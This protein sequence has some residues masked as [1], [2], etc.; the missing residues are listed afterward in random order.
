MQRVIQN[1]IYGILAA[2]MALFIGS[3]LFLRA[4][5]NYVV[6]S[7]KP[8]L[9]QQHLLIL[10][11]LVILLVIASLVVYR[12]C[13]KLDRYRPQVVIPFI[14]GISLAIQLAIIFL[15]PRLPTDDSQTV[16]SLA[17]QMLNKGDYS[18]FQSG[19][20]LYMFP[21][22]F[23]TVLYIKLLLW[24][25]PD[26]YLVLKIFNILFT[27]V[28]T[29]MIYL[30]YKQLNSRSMSRDYGVLVFAATYIPALLMSNF[31]YNDVIATTLLTA[32]LYA[33]IRFVKTR[34]IRYIVLA[35]ILLALGNY[36]RSIGIIFLIAVI[37]YMLLNKRDIG[38]RRLL[39]S[40]GIMVALFN[41]PGWTQNAALQASGVVSEPTSTH[42][43]PVYMWLNMGMNQ[44][45]FGFWDN[46]LSYTIYQREAGYNKAESIP[47]FQQAI[48][49]KLS[50]MTPGELAELYYKKLIWTWAEGT[51]QIERYGIGNERSAGGGMG[52]VMGGY[53]YSTVATQL[54]AGNSVYRSGLM[55]VLYA[56]N[57]LMYIFV[58]VRLIGAIRTRRY[59]EVALVLVILGFIGF[60]LLWEI[61]SRY[62]YPVYP[63]LIILSYIGFKDVYQ[64]LSRYIPFLGKGD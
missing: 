59:D 21:F 56:M 17:L 35:A 57:F 39:I 15:L 61:K 33:V 3:S 45:T 29:L 36:F 53:S 40:L 31:I 12:L 11:L 9:H 34:S 22:N 24:I 46:M 37:I 50:S 42:S 44:S 32:A 26:N 8:V 13:L 58:L 48:R 19:G 38:W 60:Y 10:A 25:F 4:E 41:V 16:V 28:T 51:Y 30:I 2:F 47:L 20:Y 18:T 49:D 62:I 14:L 54:F 7:D 43:A 1:A 23:S 52:F 27:L 6:Y 63:L 5:Y 64:G 55:W